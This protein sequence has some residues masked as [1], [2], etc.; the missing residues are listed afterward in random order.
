M[1]EIKERRIM[2]L[3]IIEVIEVTLTGSMKKE[4]WCNDEVKETMDGE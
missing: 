1:A 3:S 4:A 2:L